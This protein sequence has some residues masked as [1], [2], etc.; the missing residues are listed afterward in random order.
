MGV[1]V[2]RVRGVVGLGGSSAAVRWAIVVLALLWCGCAH[3]ETRVYLLRG[4]FGVFST[5]MDT[6]AEELRAKGIKAEAIGHLSWRSAVSAVV[7]ERAAG[8]TVRLVL[9]GHSQGGNNV[10]DMARELE[11]H[12]IPV[13]LLITLAPFLQEPVPANVVRAI[14]YYQTPGWGSPLV[15]VPE[16]KGELSNIDIGDWSTIHINIDKNPKIQAE[17]VR[18][19]VALQ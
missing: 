7:K 12:K 3:A 14:N 11:P 13:D 17:I 2:V 5:G 19:I 15:A 9:V 1:D 10:V 8:K 6:I 4:W 16:F 18:A